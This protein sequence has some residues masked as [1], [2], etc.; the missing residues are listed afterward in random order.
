MNRKPF[1]NS[2]SPSGCSFPSIPQI[3]V[4]DV[5]SLPPLPDPETTSPN[6]VSLPPLPPPPDV[7]CID[8]K[9]D[10]KSE[11]CFGVTLSIPGVFGTPSGGDCMD[12]RY[13]MSVDLPCTMMG[14]I[15]V[16]A[17]DRGSYPIRVSTGFTM[18]GRTIRPKDP[19]EVWPVSRNSSVA[20]SGD[21]GGTGRSRSVLAF[22][23]SG[24]AM[25][26]VRRCC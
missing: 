24:R 25:S 13:V 17:P 7:D 1:D 5:C 20:G 9:V 11:D 2:T 14:P 22:A 3:D 6:L 19:V 23:S 4:V 15:V 16:V 26:F 18:D 8:V 12:G 10:I 21:A